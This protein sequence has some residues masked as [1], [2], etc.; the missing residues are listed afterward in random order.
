[1]YTTALRS[2]KVSLSNL[3]ESRS[4]TDVVDSCDC[5]VLHMLLQ[6]VANRGGHRRKQYKR[7]RI[8]SLF[9]TSNLYP[10]AENTNLQT[11][12][13]PTPDVFVSYRVCIGH[14]ARC[15]RK[16]NHQTEKPAVAPVT[17]PTSSH[18]ANR[19][20]HANALLCAHL[21]GQRQ[22]IHEHF[23]GLYSRCQ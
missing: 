6:K 21:A 9:H 1:M 4:L 11:I 18:L 16:R 17:R 20:L 23:G 2:K 5:A 14:T 7:E 3:C 13:E 10:I 8:M 22:A 12:V 15:S 19:L